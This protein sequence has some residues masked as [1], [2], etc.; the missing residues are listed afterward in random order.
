MHN[1]ANETTVPLGQEELS[2]LLPKKIMNPTLSISGYVPR[3]CLRERRS[4]L[5]AR[6]MDL[7]AIFDNSQ[8]FLEEDTIDFILEKFP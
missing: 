4:H 3:N 5:V 8:K 7:I 2:C 6:R 1:L